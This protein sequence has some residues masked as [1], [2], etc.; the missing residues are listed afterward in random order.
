MGSVLIANSICSQ[1]VDLF[2]TYAGA[3]LIAYRKEL[4]S[5]NDLQAIAVASERDLE[6]MAFVGP[7]AE[8]TKMDRQRELKRDIEQI[9]RVL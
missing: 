1:G 2:T 8:M 7:L 6:K 4:I 5:S 3:A 9:Q